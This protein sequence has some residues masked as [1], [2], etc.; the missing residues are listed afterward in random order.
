[1]TLSV[2]CPTRDPGPRVRALLAPLREVADEVVV[3]VDSRVDPDTLGEHA[4]A[5]D[6]LV[7]FE[8]GEPNASLA[9]MHE[10]C[11][12][13]W[14]LTIA[15]DEVPSAALV[16]ALGE[17]TA[18]RRVLQTWVPTRWVFP[19]ALHWLAEWP[20]FPDFHNRLV[21]NDGT[22]RF[23][24]RKHTF[25]APALPAQ[26]VD[27]PIYH[28]PL[29]LDS[30]DERRARVTRYEGQAPGLALPGGLPLDATYYLPE[31][32]AEHALERV[33]ESDAV[34]IDRVL[35]AS[36]DGT[37]APRQVEPA[38]LAEIQRLW[39]ARAFAAAGYRA[40][41]APFE[42]PRTLR[43]RPREADAVHVRVT[44]EGG[45][46]WPWG[47]DAAPRVR[48][49]YRIAHMDG[50]EPWDGP[51]S[52]LPHELRPGESCIAPVTIEAPERPGAYQV[53][54]DLVHDPVRWFGCEVR[55]ELTVG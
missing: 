37:P 26:W 3:A 32:H 46:R 47:L 28:L 44:N 15:G 18:T 16:E 9:W 7:R 12:G 20:W 2:L 4:A 21:R 10:Q 41:V 43:L 27:A 51:R 5:A 35:G 33:P 48:L 19:D 34:L 50:G 14:V 39:A 13:D 38:P 29:V 49:G 42:P 54:V 6:R 40:R 53:A 45:E 31:R 23:P 52:P 22:L 17:L 1:M 11:R 55:F 36:P 24:G 30:E 25:A 8:Y